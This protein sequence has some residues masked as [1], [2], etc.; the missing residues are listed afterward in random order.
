[1]QADFTPTPSETTQPYWDGTKERRLV[2][3][4]CEACDRFVHHP[5]EACPSCLGSELSWTEV[6]GGGTIHALSVHTVPFEAMG[7]EDC[8]Y[9]VAF[10]ELDEGPRF[11]S[12]VVGPTRTEARAGDRVELTWQPVQSGYHLPVFRPT[13]EPGHG[14]DEG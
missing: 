3:Q 10:I 11:L 7:K 5:R 9:V 14:H 1:M 8:P 6:S 2:L 13:S 12:N 4:R